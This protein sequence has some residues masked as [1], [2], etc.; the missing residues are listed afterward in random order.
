[1]SASDRSRPSII[2][3]TRSSSWTMARPT[4]PARSSRGSR[5]SE[6]STN[7]T[8]GL[9]VARNAGLQCATGAVIAYTDS[10]CI[11][12]PD[13]LIHLVHQL[14]AERGGG[15]GGAEPDTRGWLAGR[16]RRGRAGAADP[17]PGKRPGR[18]AH[19]RLQHGLPPRGS[20]GDQRVRSPVSQGRRR[21]GHLLAAPA[22]GPLDHLRAGGIRL[23]PSPPEPAFVPQATGRLWRGRGPA[24]LQAPGQVQRPRRRQVGRGDVR[25]ARSRAFRSPSPIIY[26]GTFGTGMFQC[27]YQPG[28]AHWAMLPSTL[29]W[30]VAALLLGLAGALVRPWG[31]SSGRVCW[32]CRCWSP[33]C[34][35]PRPTLPPPT[36]AGAARLLIAAPLLC[37]AARP[38]LDAV[39]D[40]GCRRNVPRALDPAPPDGPRAAVVVDGLSVG[41]LLVGGGE[42]SHGDPETG[43][44]LHGR[45]SLG[46]GARHRLVRVGHGRLL[47]TRG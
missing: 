38:V 25:R 21:C 41:G 43:R 35:R 42:R 22:R 20:R 2:R 39:S 9:S 36:G 1:M 4:I 8:R 31:G 33:P 10:D 32:A 16:V 11:A 24:P 26:R 12:D 13:W 3:T 6:P 17:R 14:T 27:L 44:G 40:A 47:A 30:H 5:R 34:K 15:G 37:P 46:Q 7:R 23:A 19:P 29:E 45:T 28:A 18:R